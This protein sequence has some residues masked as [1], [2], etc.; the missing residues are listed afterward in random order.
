M[1]NKVRQSVDNMNVTELLSYL[2]GNRGGI[3]TSILQTMRMYRNLSK[4]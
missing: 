3:A 2:E 1:Q 4:G